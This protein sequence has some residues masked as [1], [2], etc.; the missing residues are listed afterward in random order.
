MHV[1]C[2]CTGTG[3]PHTHP[4]PWLLFLPDPLAKCSPSAGRSP[5]AAGTTRFLC[6][7]LQP[8]STCFVHA[9][10]WEGE[11]VLLRQQVWGSPASVCREKALQRIVLGQRVPARAGKPPAYKPSEHALQGTAGWSPDVAGQGKAVRT[12]PG[13]FRARQRCRE[14]GHIRVSQG[15]SFIPLEHAGTGR[16]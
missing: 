3:G 1:L 2:E 16:R 11:E 15:T 13:P 10:P 4:H 8:A 7:Q 5:T 14:R 12:E 6:R 9:R